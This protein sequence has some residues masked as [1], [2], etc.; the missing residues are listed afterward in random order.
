MLQVQSVGLHS[1]ESI[2]VHHPLLS[3][4]EKTARISADVVLGSDIR[5]L[6]F[7]CSSEY[8]E[9]LTADT[10]DA[11][12]LPALFVAMRQGRELVV[13]GPMSTRLFYNLTTSYVE[14]L[15]SLIPELRGVDIKARDLTT[16]VWGGRGAITGF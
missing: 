10:C 6:W 15:R 3:V 7:E 2:V 8:A 12:V 9:Y 11:F 14:L 13:D 4:T 1:P 16:K 5:T